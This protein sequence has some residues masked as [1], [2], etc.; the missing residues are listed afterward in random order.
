MKLKSMANSFPNGALLAAVIITLQCFHTSILAVDHQG[1]EVY[2]VYMGEKK[3]PDPEVV[4]T[5]HYDLLASILG[6]KE[7]ALASIIYSYKHGFSGFAAWLTEAQAQE[8]AELPDVISVKRNQI[9]YPQTTRS[10]DFLGLDYNNPTG[11]L[12]KTNYGDGIIIGVIDTGV[13]P[14]SASFNDKGYGPVPSRWNGTCQVG[15]NFTTSNCNRKIIG[16]RYYKEPSFHDS[17]YQGE[18]L[19]PRDANSHGTHTASTAGGNIVNDVSFFGLAS[20]A[21][22]GGA[23]NARLAIYKVC[24]G[25]T[26]CGDAAM[27]KAMDDAISDGVDVLSISI[28]SPFS[29][30]PGTLHAVAKG[31][32]VVFSGENDGP[33]PQTIGNPQPWVITVAATTVDRSFPTTITL[34]D[35]TR[36][37]GQSLLYG[38]EVVAPLYIAGSCNDDSLSGINI[39]G[40]IVFC[41]APD[42]VGRTLPTVDIGNAQLSVQKGNASGLIYAQY[43]TSSLFSLQYNVLTQI[44]TVLVDFVTA[45][46]I[47]QY[48]KSTIQSKKCRQPNCL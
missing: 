36:V 12:K 3:H 6:S 31:I 26:G 27:L 46:A 37:V 8:L 9:S 39:T 48:Y 42:L 35:N 14:E 21:A 20:G 1:K 2:I 5:S 15:Q 24:W 4:E 43:T 11:L 23:P 17:A 33:A 30:N 47:R 7:S 18:Y 10:W 38:A 16:A 45:D 29:D 32:V 28:G 44:P 22:R 34:G 25:S 40:M 41:Y 19:S 13:W